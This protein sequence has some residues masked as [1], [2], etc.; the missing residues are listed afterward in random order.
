MAIDLTKDWRPGQPLPKQESSDIVY[1]E[2]S[3]GLADKYANDI[4]Y[5][6]GKGY[7]LG[8]RDDGSRYWFKPGFFG[9]QKSITNYQ[10]YSPEKRIDVNKT[11]EN[12]RQRVLG[13]STIDEFLNNF[14]TR[15]NQLPSISQQQIISTQNPAT[16]SNQNKINKDLFNR[17]M[18]LIQ[19]FTL[20]EV[21]LGKSV[22][23][24]YNEKPS[25]NKNETSNQVPAQTT[26]S[27]NENAASID[28]PINSI[29]AQ[30]V[31][32]NNQVPTQKVQNKNNQKSKQNWFTRATM[33][34]FVAENPSFATA[35]G[36]NINPVNKETYVNNKAM[37]KGS[38]EEK[39][40]NS[41]A[42]SG[43][44]G[45]GALTG[46]LIETAG[47]EIISNAKNYI[48]QVK[49]EYNRYRKQYN[50]KDWQEQQGGDWDSDYWDFNVEEP[51]VVGE[52]TS[53]FVN[54][55]PQL[56]NLPGKLPNLP[57]K[58]VSIPGKL[59]NLPGKLVNIPGKL[60]IL[61]EKQGGIMEYFN[62]DKQVNKFASG[63]KTNAKNILTTVIQGLLSGNPEKMLQ[64]LQRVKTQP[65]GEQ[66]YNSIKEAVRELA[67]T[68][69]SAAQAIQVWEEYENQV[70]MAEQGA[71]LEFMKQL[72][73]ICPEGTEKV[74]LQNGGCMCKKAK[75]EKGDKMENKKE[76]FDAK[77]EKCGGKMKKHQ[78]GGVV[79][80]EA[81]GPAQTKYKNNQ[82]QIFYS[83]EGDYYSG[84][85]TTRNGITL[86]TGQNDLNNPTQ[87][88]STFIDTLRNLIISKSIMN[89]KTKYQGNKLDTGEYIKV[90][91]PEW[92]G[93]QKVFIK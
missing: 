36:F 14:N 64:Q 7:R 15:W 37:E 70:Q 80:K 24:Y 40:R 74:Y 90:G 21:N 52:G 82:G 4:A 56:P 71:K 29:P 67:K 79:V 50:Q 76:F 81:Y 62:T 46:G 44:V 84:K 13:T 27:N 12:T 8:T 87:I 34:A 3:S 59:P 35:T 42:I 22:G 49:D 23:G 89:G 32:T 31:Q 5:Y 43:A 45:L 17:R 39:L 58:L 55:V 93:T 10:T 28:K 68:D 51:I 48:K 16:T 66:Q 85:D 53:I 47:P 69:K 91:E 60:P 63:G 54:P 75:M 92:Q 38:P 6:T 33:N 20:P 11:V 9:K 73:G 77:K 83:D 25:F 61:I 41:M 88:D 86:I 78:V 26:R 18:Q 2:D 72:K 65:G 30:K 1:I 19:Q 57:G